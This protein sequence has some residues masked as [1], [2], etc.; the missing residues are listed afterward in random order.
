LLRLLPRVFILDL[1][2]SFRSPPETRRLAVCSLS[3][4][5]ARPSSMPATRFS[6]ALCSDLTMAVSDDVLLN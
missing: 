1:G 3:S 4:Y 5:S 6:S 2:L